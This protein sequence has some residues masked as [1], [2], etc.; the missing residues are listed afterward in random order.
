MKAKFPE[1]LVWVFKSTG[2]II[3]FL[4]T[5]C[6]ASQTCSSANI[7]ALSVSE[8]YL[9]SI[10]GCREKH[11]LNTAVLVTDKLWE[12]NNAMEVKWRSLAFLCG[13]NGCCSYCP[14]N[15]SSW[16]WFSCLLK[17][18]LQ[19]CCFKL[20]QP[21]ICKPINHVSSMPRLFSPCWG[22]VGKHLPLIAWLRLSDGRGHDD[23][24]ICHKWRTCT[25]S[26]MRRWRKF[27]T[28]QICM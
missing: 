17:I 16:S 11:L 2:C 13:L 26:Q 21:C 28:A 8:K 15:T 22:G 10:R 7:S 1:L 18:H 9:F 4:T 25:L 14:A 23:F 6:W 19:G 27:Q 24:I 3:F 20:E 12:I 5:Q